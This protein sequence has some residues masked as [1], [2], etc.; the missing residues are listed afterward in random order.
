MRIIRNRVFFLVSLVVAGTMTVM[1]LFTSY[2]LMRSFGREETAR[3]TEESQRATELLSSQVDQLNLKL[4]DWAQWDDSY[5][6]IQD[7]NTEFVKSNVN[8]EALK[9]L[10][11]ESVIFVNAEGRTVLSLSI[12]PETGTQMSL[13][14]GLEDH[15]RRGDFLVSHEDVKSAKKGILNLDDGPVLV[16]S[17]PIVR[18]DGEG[19]A[20]GTIIFVSYFDKKWQRDFSNLIHNPFSVESYRDPRLSREFSQAKAGLSSD[21]PVTVTELD[22]ASLAVYGLLNDV[23]GEPGLLFRLEL[24]R[25]MHQQGMK[26]LYVFAILLTAIG[27][28][29]FLSLSSLLRREVL[30]RLEKLSSSIAEIR[31][32]GG[33]NVPKITV[34]GDDEISLLAEKI[35]EMVE[36]LRKTKQHG[37]ESER[38]FHMIA[39]TAPIM[40]WM[41]DKTG[42]FTYLNKGWLEFTGHSAQELLGEGYVR[43]MHPS[44]SQKVSKVYHEAFESRRPFRT[45]FRLKR[46]DGEYRFMLM[47]GVPYY[48]ALGEFLGYVGVCLDIQDRRTVEV[49]R[50][51]RIEEVEKLNAAMVS[52]ELR[53]IELKE[54]V[55]RLRKELDS[56]EKAVS[57]KKVAGTGK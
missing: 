52:R 7:E 28:V 51:E 27:F 6:Y 9:I 23:Y 57:P 14:R 31:L 3:A 49:K 32:S 16:A 44:D 38:R 4:A 17:Q 25:D 15:L 37:E 26:T 12:D 30:S 29:F 2:F 21:N 48:A 43:D 24:S 18:S 39:D 11:I 34:A 45:E 13:P 41:S 50:E 54:E 36:V 53:M 46:S 19:P 33:A 35:N 5:E 8:N 55:K 47:N 22:E 40:I 42:A 1:F 10:G 20:K 56:A